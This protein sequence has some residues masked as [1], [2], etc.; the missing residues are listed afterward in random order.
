MRKISLLLVSALMASPFVSR[1][2]EGMWLPILLEKNMATMTELGFQLTADDI[3]N[4][5]SACVKDAIVAL[6]GGSCTARS[7]GRRSTRRPLPS[8]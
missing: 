8:A 2:D 4:I 3:Y 1:A 7:S 5:N 6:D